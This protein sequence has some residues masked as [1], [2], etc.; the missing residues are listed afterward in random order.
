M[1]LQYAFYIWKDISNKYIQLFKS[2][3]KLKL[4]NKIKKY[5]RDLVND[6]NKSWCVN[7]EISKDLEYKYAQL[8]NSQYRPY[9]IDIINDNKELV[10]F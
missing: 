1:K 5:H 6:I 8:T 10:I 9:I 4:T 3:D 7:N 2:N